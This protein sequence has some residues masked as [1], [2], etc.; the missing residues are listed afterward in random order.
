M[1]RV[2]RW[3]ERVK[4]RMLRRNLCHLMN[5]TL[6]T[7]ACIAA[8]G[9]DSLSLFAQAPGPRTGRGPR[10][11]GAGRA[12]FESTPLGKDDR[13]KRILAV[14]DEMNSAGRGMMSVSRDDGRF[15]R[16][17]VESMGAKQAVE[18][19]TSQGYSAVWTALALGKTG[20]KLTTYEIDEGRARLARENFKKAGVEDIITLVLGDAHQ[21][22]KKQK[23]EID[24]VFLDADKQGYIDYLN[25][26][27]PLLRPGGLVVAHNITSGQADPRYIEAITKNPDLETLFLVAAQNISVTMK[28]R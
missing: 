21:E 10:G 9:L 3:Q 8:I 6:L 1:R 27:L 23:G 4:W 16:M 20:G 12:D 14:L 13:E 7:F 19:G 24:F 18:L 26:L 22:L 28:K 2:F 5:T 25:T 11:P 17:L 15:L